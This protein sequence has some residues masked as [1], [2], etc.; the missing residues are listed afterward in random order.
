[1][2]E[3]EYLETRVTTQRKYFSEKATSYKKYYYITSILKLVISLVITVMSSVAFEISP[4]SILIAV[5]SALM[6]LIEGILLLYKFNENWITYRMTSENLKKE[7]FLFKTRSGEY[8]MLDD[9]QAL[10]IFVQNTETV[11]QNSNKHWEGIYNNKR[12]EN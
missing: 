10:N 9:S 8:Y 5:L 6:A 4:V 1:M 3:Q 7:E 11:I 12:G 2:T